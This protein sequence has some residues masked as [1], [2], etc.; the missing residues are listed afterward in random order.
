MAYLA[1]GANLK[2]I[3]KKLQLSPK[4]IEAH[5][6]NIK[7]K[8]GINYKADLVEWFHEVKEI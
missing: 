6:S 7:L 5:V 1:N 4:T 3:A 2:S 8:T